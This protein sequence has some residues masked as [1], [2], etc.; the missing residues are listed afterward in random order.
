LQ[1]VYGLCFGNEDLNDHDQLRN[2]PL[3]ALLCG[4]KDMEGTT[5]RSERRT[6]W[7]PPAVCLTGGRATRGSLPIRDNW[8]SFLQ[9][10]FCERPKELRGC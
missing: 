10:R 9:G 4:K 7:K 6:D 2:D 5:R 8:R 3:L 1:R